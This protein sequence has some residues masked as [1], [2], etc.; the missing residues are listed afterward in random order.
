[1]S[2]EI[3]AIVSFGCSRCSSVASAMP[4]SSP[5][6]RMSHSARSKPSSPGSASASAAQAHRRGPAPQS[7]SSAARLSAT[8]RL[9]STTSTSMPGRSGG[10]AGQGLGLAGRAQRERAALGRRRQHEAEDRAAPR[11]RTQGDLHAQPQGQPAHDRQPQAVA[12]LQVA[13]GVADLLEVAEDPLLRLR[14]DADAGVAHLD[15]PA[16]AA[17][18]AGQQHAAVRRELERV[19]DQVAEDAP[20]RSPRRSRPP[21]R[22]GSAPSPGRWPTGARIRAS[23]APAAPRPA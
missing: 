2:A 9:S 19:V 10:V 22:P 20:Q 7:R 16:V 5:G 12:A 13:L 17:A 15:A 23:A 1:M 14:R 4:S 8:T 18:P 3:S 6:S 11:R 21:R